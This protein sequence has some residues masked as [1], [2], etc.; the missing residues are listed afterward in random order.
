MQWI[1]FGVVIIALILMGSRSPKLALSILVLLLALWLGFYFHTEGKRKITHQLVAQDKVTLSGFSVTPGYR[2]SYN[3]S[4][5]I[6][7][8]STTETITEVRLHIDL[9]DCPRET[10]VKDQKCIVVGNIVEIISIIIPPRQAR[11]IS[12]NPYFGATSLQGQPRWSY[13]IIGIKTR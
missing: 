4:A 6:T 10:E 7:N 12:R 3:L 13:K 1:L 5:R 2:E 9:E 11:D 8:K